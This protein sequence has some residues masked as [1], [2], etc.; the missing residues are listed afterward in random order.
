MSPTGRPLRFGRAA[1]FV[2]PAAAVVVAALVFLGP[3]A[4]RPALGARLHGAPAEGARAASLRVEIVTSYYGTLE[5]G[6]PRDLA[7]QATAPGQSLT[8]WQGLTDADGVA[9]VSLA[10][11]APLRGPL[12]VRVATEGPH[13][14]LLAGGEI[15][16]GPPPPAIV[17][18]SYLAGTV[19]GDLDVRVIASRGVFAAP[20]P[21]AVRVDV[22]PIP[23][24]GRAEIELSGPGLRV[25]P[26]K[27]VVDARGEAIFTVEALAHEV[28]LGITARTGERSA[29]W[30]G[31]LPVI[32]GAMRLGRVGG[33]GVVDLLSPAPRERAYVSF[34][35]EQGRVAGAIVPLARDPQGFHAGKLH[36]P[37]LSG[38]RV[39]YATV[40]GDPVE[41]GAGTVAWPL[42]PAEGTVVHRPIGLLLDGLPGALAREEQRSW[43]A[44]RAGLVLIGAAALA[45]ALLLLLMSRASQRKLE[46]HLVEASKTMPAADRARLLGAAREHPA[47]RALLAVALV[48]LAFAM[49]AALSSF[50]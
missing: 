21:E 36:L 42:R 33:D 27:L 43:A 28:E 32:P 46:A 34:W 45:E 29:R 40:A 4:L 15:P 35:T 12:A 8:A 44:R 49:M 13:P 18:P 24:D 47:L 3:G 26:A 30:E 41:L 9:E 10:A 38:A 20:F 19:H 39:L 7:V 25:T 17:Q 2:L 31:T 50:R 23:P 1:T 6:A 22:S 16:L 37:D 11:G 48:G 5:R 14:R